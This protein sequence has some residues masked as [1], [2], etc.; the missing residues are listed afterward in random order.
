MIADRRLRRRQHHLREEGARAPRARVRRDPATRRVVERAE[1]LIVPGRRSLRRDRGVR[2]R[3]VWERPSSAPSP[4]ARRCSASAWACSGSLSAPTRRPGSPGSVPFAGRCEP[5]P[6]DREVAARRLGPARDRAPGRLLRGLAPG[7]FVYFTHGYRAPLVAETVASCRLRR[8]VTRRSSS[9]ATSSACSSTPEKSGRGRP[10][11]PARTS[12]H[13][14][15]AHHRLSRHRRR[16]GRQGRASSSTCATP[17]TPSSWRAARRRRRRRDRPARHLRHPAG[18][19]TALDVV[20]RAA[21][22]LF[23]PFTV[24]GGIASVAGGGRGDRGGRRQ[25]RRQLGGGRRPG[26]D[27]VDRHP[28]RLA[29]RGRRHRRQASPRRRRLGGVGCR[30]PRPTGRDALQWAQRGERARRR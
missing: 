8:A 16:T 3:W 1:R 15:Q 7:V 10:R 13:A 21:R 20:R 12:A 11:H 2:R 18:T 29:G 6:A 23:I 9:A 27:R 28:L 30:R 26:A 17:A 25:G 22:E 24:G 19:Q 14:E 4:R 5:L